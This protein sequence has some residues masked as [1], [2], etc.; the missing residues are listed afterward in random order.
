MKKNILIHTMLLY[1][2]LFSGCTCFF[3]VLDYVDENNKSY[4][5]LLNEDRCTVELKYLG[6]HPNYPDTH[7]HPVD[8]NTEILSH[9]QTYILI[10]NKDNDK[11][12]IQDCRL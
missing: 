12:L 3:P 4:I 1:L 2:F 8:R 11:I 9:D 5:T 10:I 6:T 7:G